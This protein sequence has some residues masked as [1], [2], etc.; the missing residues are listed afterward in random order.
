MT[1]LRWEMFESR[2]ARPRRAPWTLAIV[3]AASLVVPQ[4]ST[5]AGAGATGGAERSSNTG[6]ASTGSIGAWS[7]EADGAG[8]VIRWTGSETLP[9]GG[10][11]LEVRRD[12]ELLGVAREV[13]STAELRL[14]SRPRALDQLELWRGAH[15]VDVELPDGGTGEGGVT[16]DRP[17]TRHLGIDPGTPGPYSIQRLGYSLDGLAWNEFVQPIEV[18]A[19]VTAPVGALGARPFVLILHGRHATCF[20][21]G[22]TG[23]ASGDWPCPA[24]WAPIPSYLGYRTMTDLLA[25]QG[26]VTIS[27]SANAIN[28]QDYIAADGGAAARSALVRH[29]LA[30]WTAWSSI[31]GD[32]FGGRFFGRVDMS[33][34]V[35]VGHSRGGEGVARA[36]VDSR[37]SNPWRILGVVPIGPTAFG[38]QVP[39]TVHTMVLLPRCDGDVSDLQGQLFVDNGR[40]LSD[41]D[42]SLRSAVMVLGANHNFFNAEWT[43]GLAAAPAEDDWIY[44]GDEHDA[45]CGV[46]SPKRLR[47]G[48]QQAVGATYVATLARLAVYG[49]ERVLPLL[50]GPFGAPNS[51]K[52]ALVLVAA[53]G[54]ERSLLYAPKVTG[55]ARGSY[56]L[57]TRV[58]DGWSFDANPSCGFDFSSRTPHWI[59]PQFVS[60]LPKPKA[61]EL[62]WRGMGLLALPFATPV[63]LSGR[64]RI[65]LRIAVDP[66]YDANWYTAR[67]QDR[68]GNTAWLPISAE[69]RGFAGDGLPA[70]IWAQAVRLKLRDLHGIDLRHITRVDIVAIAGAGAHGD[71]H[72]YLLDAMAVDSTLPR[73]VPAFLP[74]ASVR[75]LT[76]DED[77]A[78]DRIV[79]VPVRLYGPVSRPGRVWLEVSAPDGIEGRWLS[80]A[81]GQLSATIPIHVRGDDTR[82][83]DQY[84]TITLTPG[85]NLTTKH[86]YAVVRVVDDELPPTVTADS[87]SVSGSEATGLTWTLHLSEPQ[88]F[89]FSVFAQFAAPAAG[90]ELNSDD[91]TDDAWSQWVGAPKPSPAQTLSD[92][93]AFQFVEF[94]P[95]ATTATVSVPLVVDG[96]TEGVEHVALDL[97]LD[98]VVVATLQGSISDS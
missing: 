55:I 31:G 75:D 67:L 39:A 54:G 19:E 53:I 20:Q 14:E 90:S 65:D 12:G 7:V 79:D 51:A 71:G 63:D 46:D 77:D 92:A 22:P 80:V 5:T 42:K 11:R 50:D 1:E 66:A 17:Q 4:V 78:P 64:E 8:V 41:G 49:D 37:R 36:A 2:V 61:L 52:G 72:A 45:V 91:V 16:R 68:A 32:P 89:G 33:K 44:S 18:R 60:T 74:Q 87:V 13:G 83:G 47:P 43:P 10:A 59:P 86:Y 76:I 30:L 27:I 85:H 84:F 88:P 9:I 40:E 6:L 56:G 25:S 15:R 58:C 96:V 70:K 69:A 93:F 98:G 82:G 21:G 97:W 94:A 38:R 95:N 26:Y 28:A 81:P 62:R 23:S 57:S 35:L 73:V 48:A 24:G 3:A 34:V 29:H